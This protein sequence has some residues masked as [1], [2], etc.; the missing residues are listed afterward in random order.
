MGRGGLSWQDRTDL[1][2]RVSL[3]AY[4]PLVLY[5]CRAALQNKAVTA[6]QAVQ[7]AKE[8]KL[9]RQERKHDQQ[10]ASRLE[11][12]LSA[13]WSSTTL[14][15]LGSTDESMTVVEFPDLDQ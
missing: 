8:G 5:A 13:D 4:S 14:A 2:Q 15:L 1:T 7:W 10:R 6:C 9:R 12:P 3:R 11:R